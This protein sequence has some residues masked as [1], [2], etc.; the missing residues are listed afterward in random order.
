MSNTPVVTDVVESIGEQFGIRVDPDIAH[1]L[2]G[3]INSCKQAYVPTNDEKLSRPTTD[4]LAAKDNLV[5]GMIN[6]AIRQIPGFANIDFARSR[7]DDGSAITH[8]PISSS[9]TSTTQQR[10]VLSPQQRLAVSRTPFD[11]LET[12][13]VIPSAENVISAIANSPVLNALNLVQDTLHKVRKLPTE[14]YLTSSGWI[15]IILEE[16]DNSTL[17]VLN[18]HIN[19]EVEQ[20]ISVTTH[21]GSRKMVP[22]VQNDREPRVNVIML[23]RTGGADSNPAM[24]VSLFGMQLRL[25]REMGIICMGIAMLF[26]AFIFIA[27]AES[28]RKRL[29]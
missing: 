28:R 21:T 14:A 23:Q 24:T 25:D 12:V 29:Y 16:S 22:F 10:Q 26:A 11:A 17:P 27:W 2:R 9:M 1:A 5:Q 20:Q 18:I 19:S 3:L 8:S 6:D 4:P 15:R 7:Y 13:E